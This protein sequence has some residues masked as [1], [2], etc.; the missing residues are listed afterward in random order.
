MISS[1]MKINTSRAQLKINFVDLEKSLK[2]KPIIMNRFCPIEKANI[3]S[4]Q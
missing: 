4:M 2:E 1:I 3:Y